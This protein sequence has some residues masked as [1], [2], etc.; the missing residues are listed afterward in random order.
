MPDLLIG[1]FA[2]RGFIKGLCGF[3]PEVVV[4]M[5]VVHVEVL[6]SIEMGVHLPASV[7]GRGRPLL[8]SSKSA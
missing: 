8:E 3:G 1:G 7:T 2:F 6:L 4:V 5:M